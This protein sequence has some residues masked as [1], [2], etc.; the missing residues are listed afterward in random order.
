MGPIFCPTI[1][2]IAAGNVSSIIVRYGRTIELRG[3]L[4]RCEDKGLVVVICA[5]VQ[6]GNCRCLASIITL[7]MH[8]EYE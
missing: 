5:R 3:V 7:N 2:G 6:D 4:M 1:S 8:E